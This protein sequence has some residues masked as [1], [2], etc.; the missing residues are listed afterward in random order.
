MN[1]SNLELHDAI[2][3]TWTVDFHDQSITLLVDAYMSES[4]KTRRPVGIKFSGV[5]NLT[6]IADLEVIVNNNRSGNINYW[7]PAEE[8]GVSYIYLNEGCIAIKA[9]AIQID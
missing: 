6:C 9:L 1:P 4:D 8:F 3:R 5:S 2:L 7:A